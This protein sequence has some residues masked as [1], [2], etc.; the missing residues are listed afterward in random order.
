MGT[1]VTAP[2]HS[3]RV[4]NL[5]TAQAVRERSNVLFEKA[6]AGDLKQAGVD[7]AR[8]PEAVA[9][10]LTAI[11]QT[12]PDFQIP[13]YG[14]WRAF[15]VGER[16]RW[17]ILAGAR[18]F[19][20]PEDFL[21]SAADLAILTQAM[22]VPLR[23]DWTFADPITD[24][25]VEGREG[26]AVGALSMFASGSFSSNPADP[27]RV[28]AHA[29]IR[30]QES[31]IVSGL[32]LD[33]QLDQTTARSIAGLLK[34]LGETVGLRPDLFDVDGDIRP[35]C[36]LTKFSSGTEGEAAVLPALL[37]ALLDGLSPMWP[38]GATLEDVVLGDCWHHSAL[39]QQAEGPGIVPFHLVAQE[40]AYS[41]IEPL[42]WV[43]VEV[44]GLNELTGFAN[45]EHAALFLETGVLFLKEQELTKRAGDL[46]RTIELRALT[47]AL[48]DRLADA[49]RTDLDVSAEILPLP[50]IM[51]GGTLRAGAEIMRKNGDFRSKVSH[52]LAAGA[53]NWLPFCA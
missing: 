47:V 19:E 37:A 3:S 34:R 49:L 48:F 31:E 10:T 23:E 39:L 45:L 17:A 53:V 5:L 2:S 11:K 12:Y 35:G 9:R 18:A 22:S 32:Q 4:E 27:L 52:L 25:V 43:G 1:T 40:M 46:D 44:A 21:R 8:L 30:L 41:L 42:A 6:V 16:D 33:A 7:L 24:D 13:P 50:C 36:L 20:T 15:E 14:C 28:D 26:L 51:E 29:L 38:G